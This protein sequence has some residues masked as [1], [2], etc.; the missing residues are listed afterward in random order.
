[1][2]NNFAMY[3]WKLFKKEIHYF[4]LDHKASRFVLN[5][6]YTLFMCAASAMFFAIGFRSFISLDAESGGTILHLATG[7]MSGVAQCIVKIAQLF[8][9]DYN[10]NTLQSIFYFVLNIP[11]LVFSF[12]KVGVKFSIFTSLNVLFVSLFIQILPA[13]VFVPI[14]KMIANDVLARAVFAGI[15]TGL[16]SSCAFVANHSAGGIDIIAYYYSMRKSVNTGK[17][18]VIMN[19]LIVVCFTSIVM[20]ENNFSNYALALITACYSVAYLFVGS[21]V[22]DF[23]NARNKKVMLQIITENESLKKIIAANVPH[24]CTITKG[25]GGFGGK[26]KFIIYTVIS[27]REVESLVKKIR[28]ADPTS[29]INATA[30]RQVYGK[31]YIKPV[32]WKTLQNST[33]F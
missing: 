1:M 9:L 6:G 23:I 22:V 27:S 33:I 19:G 28:K 16:S 11:L 18:M 13:E 7:G 31:F 15:L 25:E 12:M 17:Y 30:L 5:N 2:Y 32:E 8:G 24:S 14:Q 29:F 21:L 20:S 26:S 3:K 10:Y 4:F